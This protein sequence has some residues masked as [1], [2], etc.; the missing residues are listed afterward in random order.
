[1]FFIP[2]IN[3]PNLSLMRHSLTLSRRPL[4]PLY[5]LLAQPVEHERPLVV[6]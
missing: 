3:A 5:Y 2:P 6:I 4:G 1:M